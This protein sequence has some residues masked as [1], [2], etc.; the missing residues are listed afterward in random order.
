MTAD[1]FNSKVPPPADNVLLDLWLEDDFE[2]L[3]MSYRLAYRITKGL[4]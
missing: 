3:I 4:R 1:R 2:L